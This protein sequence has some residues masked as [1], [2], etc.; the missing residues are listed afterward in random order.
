MSKEEIIVYTGCTASGKSEAA[1]IEAER[2]GGEIISADSMQL[3]RDLPIGTAQ[4][5]A[6]ERARVPHHLV[7]IFELS[8][9]ASVTGFCELASRAV[10]DIRSR[11]KI[12][13]L[14]GGTGLYIK[15][16]ICGMDDLPADRQ[17][18]SELDAEYDRPEAEEKLFE[19]MRGLDPAALE[20]WQ[21]CRRKLIRALE[22]RLL[23]GKSIIELQSHQICRRRPCHVRMI[24]RDSETLKQRIA[25][26]AKKMTDT[27]WIG[28]AEQAI[29]NGLFSSPTAHQALGYTL[30]AAFLTGEFSR[31]TLI[32]RITV[33]TWQYARRQRTWFRHQEPQPDEIIR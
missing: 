2:I 33:A 22:V 29:A 10:E 24:E 27:G 19:K 8:E 21:D 12:P 9:R 14:C 11:G 20:K 32:E 23:S 18:R 31:E 3:Y 30:I 15:S 28:E 7:G 1:L 25:A 17:L 5:T 16:F 13:I 4:P 26:R 6:E